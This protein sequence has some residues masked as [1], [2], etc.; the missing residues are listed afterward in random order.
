MECLTNW[1]TINRR[2]KSQCKEKA[3]KKDED[4]LPITMTEV[5][6]TQAHMVSKQLTTTYISGSTVSHTSEYI[7]DSHSLIHTSQ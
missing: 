5:E 2:Q 3:L 1:P 7:I 4:P 6:A